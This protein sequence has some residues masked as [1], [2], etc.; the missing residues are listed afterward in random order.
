MYPHWNARDNYR[1]GL[2]KKKRKRDKSDD[3]GTCRFP[4][5]ANAIFILFFSLVA[6][7]DPRGSVEVLRDG[8]DGA[9]GAHAALPGLVRPG[10]LREAQKETP[11]KR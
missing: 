8:Q 1:Y 3:P 9:A 4:E 10:Q 11:E 7:A 5:R 2:K 6:R